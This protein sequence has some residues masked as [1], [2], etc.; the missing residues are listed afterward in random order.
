MTRGLVGAVLQGGR[1]SR[2]G[3]NKALVSLDGR[4]LRD[5]MRALLAPLC[6]RVVLVG[7]VDADVVDD[8]ATAGDG[9]FA[10]V[11]SLLRSSAGER[12]LVVPTDMPALPPAL[13]R[14]LIDHDD[15]DDGGRDVAFAA[16][17]LPLLVH[18]RSLSRIAAAYAA[19]E[20]RVRALAEVV[21]DVPAPA[22]GVAVDVDSAF[23]NVNT[24]AD[25]AALAAR[26][27]H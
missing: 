12:F 18:R 4:A 25:L 5:H 27:R 23:A 13:L 6:E 19:G 10:A 3:T 21:V 24:P 17:P 8:P 9:P 2:M 26:W 7:G 16:R 1:S 14:A 11:L 15:A 20:R 22:V